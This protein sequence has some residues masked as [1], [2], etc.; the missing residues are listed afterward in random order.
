ML[1]SALL[2][3]YSE[4]GPLNIVVARGSSIVN[5]IRRPYFHNLI[6]FKAVYALIHV[7]VAPLV[8][9]I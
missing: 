7:S 2:L 9:Q 5:T 4:E 3:N 8:N 6:L 1:V